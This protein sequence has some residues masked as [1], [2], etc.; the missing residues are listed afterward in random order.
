MIR[1]YLLIFIV[2][3]S[4]TSYSQLN[5][6]PN[7]SFEDTVICP[8]GLDNMTE[9]LSWFSFGNSAD[10]FNTCSSVMNVPNTSFGYQSAHSGNAFCGVATYLKANHP[11]GNNYREYIGVQLTS[12]LQIGTRYYFSFYSVAADK[13]STGFLS[14]NIGLRFFSSAYSK[15][16]PAPLDNFSHVKYDSILV[17]SINWLKISGSFI[18]DSNYQYVCIGNFY[19]YLHTDTLAYIPFP[20]SA[21]YYIDDI[22][23]TTDSLFNETWTG[24]HDIE[25][26]YVQVFPNPAHEFVQFKSNQI[27]DEVRIFDSRG[28]YIRKEDCNSMECRIMIEGLDEGLYFICFGNSKYASVRRIVKFLVVRTAIDVSDRKLFVFSSSMVSFEPGNLPPQNLTVTC[29]M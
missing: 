27:I 6:V 10:Y 20:F 22:C 13:G 25:Q 5:L 17:D 29:A 11:N 12:I 3:I 26:D 24:I 18:A 8:T 9:V 7:P 14:N 28:K 21:Y 15:F 19:D 1:Y 23:V 16:N 4:R 2:L